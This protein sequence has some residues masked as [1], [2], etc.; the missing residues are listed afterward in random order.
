METI[1]D[2]AQLRKIILR[3]AQAQLPRYAQIRH[4]PLEYGKDVVAVLEM[5]GRRLL[6]M[7]QAKI[8]DITMP[9]W[10]E[11]RDEL[12]EMYLVPLASLQIGFE[13]DEREGI[14]VC[15]GHANPSVEPV[16][17]GWF[18]EQEHDH[19][20]AFRFLHLDGLVNWIVDDRLVNE[21]RAALLELGIEP[22]V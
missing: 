21:F 17:S 4:G 10:R 14:L 13:V 5:R 2:E 12:E 19:R 15:N 16:M 7:W 6:R 3:L 8:G 20:R 22:V 11:S 1:R 18:A 9:K